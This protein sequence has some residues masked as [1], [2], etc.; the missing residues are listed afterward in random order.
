MLVSSI[1][2]S[3][4]SF[5]KVYGTSVN[6]IVLVVFLINFFVEF[7]EAVWF[8]LVSGLF[9]DFFSSV[10]P[11]TFMF[12]FLISNVVLRFLISKFLFFKI[13]W[14]AL[15][16]YFLCYSVCLFLLTYF[17]SFVTINLNF[18]YPQII[19]QNYF[20]VSV[21]QFALNIIFIF[22]IYFLMSK[23]FILLDSIENSK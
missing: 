13:I 16:F 4:F 19:L 7:E 10:L 9:L 8:S 5:Y 18:L 6:L 11:G 12:G 23:F 1:G 17:F 21:I 15:P 3:V 20:R 22:P 2:E 14:K